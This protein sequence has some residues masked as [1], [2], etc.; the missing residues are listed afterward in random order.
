[1]AVEYLW[2]V[3]IVDEKMLSAIEDYA[4]GLHSLLGIGRTS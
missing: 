1:M 4:L 3:K 2:L